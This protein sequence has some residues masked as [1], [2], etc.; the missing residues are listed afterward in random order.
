VKSFKIYGI[1]YQLE[2]SS[3]VPP[4]AY[5]YKGTIVDS[6]PKGKSV[7]FIKMRDGSII[8]C[9]KSFNLAFIFVPVIIVLFTAGSIFTYLRYFQSKDATVGDLIIKQGNDN[10]IVSYNGF[11][12]I[13]DN[14]VSVQFQNGDYPCTIE[15]K[16]DGITC[17]PITL[18]PGEFIAT[19]PIEYTTDKGIVYAELHITTDTSSSVQNVVIE[20][21]NNNTPDSPDTGLEGYWKGEYIYGSDL[22]AT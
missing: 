11:M 12:G 3:S 17:S 16:G 14:T 6:V 8:E 1:P 7:G 21:P 5:G 18:E 9:F 13:H 22:P 19:L 10:N 2:P 4:D 20:I 15:L